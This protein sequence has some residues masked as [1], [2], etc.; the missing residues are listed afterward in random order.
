MSPDLRVQDEVA[1]S[2]ARTL[3]GEA[4]VNE[5]LIARVRLVAGTI[6]AGM[7]LVFWAQGTG[8]DPLYR[9][10]TFGLL[11]VGL[12]THRLLRKGVWHKSFPFLIPSLDAGFIATRTQLSFSFHE[13]ATL[14]RGM[15]LANA[16]GFACIVALTGAFRLSRGAMAYSAALAMGMYLWFA[17]QTRLDVAQIIVQSTI[18]AAISAIGYGL[19]LQ[20]SR[21]VRSE[22][23]ELTLRRLLPAH[24]IDGAHDDPVALLTQPR[25]IDASVLVTDIRGFTA[26]AERK[27]PIEVLGF[28]NVIQGALAEAVRKHGGTVDKFMGDGMLAVFGAPEPLPD[29]ARRALAAAQEMLLV[30]ERI[31]DEHP[32]AVVRIGVG[33]HSGELVVGCLGSGLRMEFTV[34]GDT[35]NI[36]SRLESLTKERGVSLLVSAEL[37]SRLQGAHTLR[38][39]GVVPIRGRQEGLAVFTDADPTGS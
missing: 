8:V 13:A 11:G 30:M 33:V 17:M 22:V 21:A 27:A 23:A 39:L 18:V 29:H 9:L 31:R 37:V 6:L 14:E 38:A 26:W 25:S 3:K 28:L 16:L 12:I 36:A 24:V 34:L 4:R 5:L 32:E 15:E 7:E 19:T 35:V 2:I 1:T 20:V 10:P